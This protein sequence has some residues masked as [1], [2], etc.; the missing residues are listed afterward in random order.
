MR[1]DDLPP[2]LQIFYVRSLEMAERMTGG[3]MPLHDG[4]D[5]LHSAA[6]WSGL[7]EKYGNDRIQAIMAKAI[8]EASMGAKAED[9]FLEARC[10]GQ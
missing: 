10:S 5:M 4:V 7:I 6:E 2:S 3:R 9:G 8:I 1:P